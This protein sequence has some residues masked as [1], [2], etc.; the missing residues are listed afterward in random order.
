MVSDN[1]KSKLR[2]VESL[3]QIGQSFVN[4]IQVYTTDIPELSGREIYFSEG[5]EYGFISTSGLLHCYVVGHGGPKIS[6]SVEFLEDI[7]VAD[8]LFLLT[9]EINRGSAAPLKAG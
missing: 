2:L 6:F 1:L 3:K 7:P 9:R 5:N 4:G 8:I